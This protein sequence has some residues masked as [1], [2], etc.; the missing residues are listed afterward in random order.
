MR[1]E[2]FE[3]RV[4]RRIAGFAP[5]LLQA[6][7]VYDWPGNVRELENEI[8]RLVTLAEDGQILQVEQLSTKFA[9]K[10]S[11]SLEDEKK[12]FD[13]LRDAI[14]DLEKRMIRAALEKFHGN[15]SQMART[16]GLSRLG[17]Q[18]KME[19]LGLSRGAVE[20]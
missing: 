12:S 6:L 15:K 4:G 7:E 14:D 1:T 2:N 17:L 11:V 3:K 10:K 19:R 18:R 9:R 8:E 13:K 5:E 16:L 20:S